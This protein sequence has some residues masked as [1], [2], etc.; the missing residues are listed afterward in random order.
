[1]G[2]CEIC[3]KPNAAFGYGPPAYPQTIWRCGA[4]RLE[5]PVTPSPPDAIQ[6]IVDAWIAAHW[7]TESDASLCR[8][9]R[10]KDDRLIPLGYGTRPRV[11]CISSAQIPIGP[12]LDAKP[13]PLSPH[14]KSGPTGCLS[15][16]ARQF[17]SRNSKVQ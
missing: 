9:C 13:S 5:G 6:M 7:P 15:L 16:C 3:G 1:M 8:H 11:W 10:R 12:S 2:P 4:H 17:R 14:R